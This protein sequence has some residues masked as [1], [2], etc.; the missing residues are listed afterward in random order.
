MLATDTAL[1]FGSSAATTL[2][3]VLNELADSLDIDRLERIGVK[4][5]V[6]EIVATRPIIF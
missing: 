1:D 4:D 2:D 5:L 3:T 6:A